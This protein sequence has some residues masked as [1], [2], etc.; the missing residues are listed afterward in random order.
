MK[1]ARGG[2]G[3]QEQEQDK[4]KGARV[5]VMGALSLA[6]NCGNLFQVLENYGLGQTIGKYPV[7]GSVG[8]WGSIST[9]NTQLPKA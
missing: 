5:V 3:E 7:V 1:S 4:A 2:A 6:T 8:V 9:L